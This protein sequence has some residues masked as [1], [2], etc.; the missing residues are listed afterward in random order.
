MKTKL[1]LLNQAKVLLEKCSCPYLVTHPR[2]DGDTIGSALALR[3]AL[4]ALDKSPVVA[5]IHPIPATLGYLPGVDTFVHTV[6]QDKA[7]DLIVAVDMSDLKRTGG[8]VPE[9]WIGRIPLLVIDHHE[10]NEAFG[11]VNIVQPQAAATAMPMLDL[12]TALGVPVGEDIATCLLTGI[13]TDTRGL[14]TE[15][16]TPQVLS[17]VS[18]LIEAGGDYM[19]VVQYALDSVPYRQMQAWGV[20]L[21]RLQLDDGI[22]WATFPLAEKEKFG[23]EDHD[24]LNLSNFLS[25][26]AEA[27]IVIVFLEMRDGTVKIS[28]R[29]RP[30]YNVA[31]VAKQLGGGGH[32]L[33]AGCSIS[34]S[35]DE[36][37]AQVLPMLREEINVGQ[38]IWPVSMT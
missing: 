11:D 38:A 25:R 33:A 22:V 27:K 14:R 7:I 3:L 1:I 30:G 19:A 10:T 35:L 5:C 34:G 4:L 23:L 21:N 2:P 17:L 26:I 16:T 24:D 12:I 31:R 29:A 15:A 8:L 13:L 6:P 9:S 32:R 28:M 37:V 20:A 36:V 18:Q